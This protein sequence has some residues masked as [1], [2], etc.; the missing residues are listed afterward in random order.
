MITFRITLIALILLFAFGL[1]N[2]NILGPSIIASPDGPIYV[3]KPI[4]VLILVSDKVDDR[5]GELTDS[6]MILNYKPATSQISML[7]IPRDTRV[8]LDGEYH[9][10]NS[11]YAHRTRPDDGIALLKDC[12]HQLVD[13]HIDYYA[14]LKI[15]CIK[16]I[17]DELDGV[18]YNVPCRMKYSTWINLKKGEQKLNGSKVVQL[19]RFRKPDAAPGHLLP[20]ED[21]Y[22]LADC[23]IYLDGTQR[24][25]TL[26]NFLAE[27]IKQKAKKEILLDVRKVTKLLQI[28]IDNSE[29]NLR[30]SDLIK[31]AKSASGLSKSKL[32]AF[33]LNGI[34]EPGFWYFVYDQTLINNTT[35]KVYDAKKVIQKYFGLEVITPSPIPTN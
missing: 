22:R 35:K 9:K 33:R 23:E 15:G 32:N 20:D 3:P 30:F 29:T 13:V 4:N 24:V 10:I 34:D 28:T 19:L 8:M 21:Q 18:W 16:K 11:V 25:R 2:L 12:I 1:N 26:Q 27:F 5:S 31:Y 17:V 14:V 6:I 7:S